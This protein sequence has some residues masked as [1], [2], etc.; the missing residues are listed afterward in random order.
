MLTRYH[1]REPQAGPAP[2]V[3]AATVVELPE[4]DGTQI[5]ILG[6]H[7]DEH[8]TV[9]HMRW[10]ATS[11]WRATGST[12]GESGPLPVLWMCD[13]SGRWHATR[14]NGVSPMWGPCAARIID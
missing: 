1:R 10:P 5:A 14:T 8:G 9:L 12:P 13:S 3:L 2:G 4:L 11:R 6:L 7:H